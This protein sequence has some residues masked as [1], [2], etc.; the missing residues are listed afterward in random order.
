MVKVNKEF[1]NGF[2]GEP[3]VEF[4]CKINENIDKFV[5]WQ[6]YFEGLLAGCF[7]DNI[8]EGGLLHS[9]INV[10]GFYDESPWKIPNIAIV[11]DELSYFRKEKF[12]TNCSNMASTIENL[13]VELQVFLSNSI[14]KGSDVYIDYN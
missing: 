6:G 1:Y 14:N 8:K 13:K 4:I 2:E 7:R 12:N 11:I 9:Y 5:I 3:E 10:D